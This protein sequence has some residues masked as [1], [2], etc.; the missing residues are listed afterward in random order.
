MEFSETFLVVLQTTQSDGKMGTPGDKCSSTLLF[1]KDTTS[2]GVNKEHLVQVAC[3]G[4]LNLS[5]L[6]SIMSLVVASYLE[7]LLQ[8]TSN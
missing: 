7:F 4:L 8:Y 5:V 1:V 3:S 6:F 2:F